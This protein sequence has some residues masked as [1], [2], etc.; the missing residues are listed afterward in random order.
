MLKNVG[1]VDKILRVIIGL[2]L[3]SMLLW[4]EG[5]AKYWGLIGIVPLVTGLTGRCPA[6]LPLKINTCKI[7]K[8]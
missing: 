7:E 2:F 5:S 3:L 8:K 1:G 6:Y 4:V